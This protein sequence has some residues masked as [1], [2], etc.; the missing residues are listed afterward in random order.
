MSLQRV[1]R[2]G[3]GRHL[4][5]SD[6]FSRPSRVIGVQN[7]L[8]QLC[9]SSK[10]RLTI[11]PVGPLSVITSQ[12]S[13]SFATK[14]GRPKTKRSTE[15]PE[16]KRKKS[17]TSKKSSAPKKKRELTEKQKEDKVKREARE[18]IKRLKE[19]ALQ[20]PKNLPQ[21]VWPIAFREKFAE[22][23]H[24][25]AKQT[26]AFSAT[27]ASIKSLSPEEKEVGFSLSRSSFNC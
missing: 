2:A 14:V 20:L 16:G 6:A 12:Q 23:K 26:E 22:I 10:P 18:Q 13:H 25:H 27:A 9:L 4:Y 5:L 19:K 8:R 17:S 11:P 24:Q 1:T 15:A 7:Q 3:V 21:N